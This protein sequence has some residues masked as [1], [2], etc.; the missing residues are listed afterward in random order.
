[1]FVHVDKGLEPADLLPAS[2][3]TLT[4]LLQPS[5][6]VIVSIIIYQWTVVTVYGLFQLIMGS[7]PHPPQHFLE[8]HVYN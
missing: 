2:A 8:G 3:V 4:M 7:F 6:V 5:V 1:M